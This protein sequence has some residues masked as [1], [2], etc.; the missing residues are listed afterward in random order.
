MTELT[1]CPQCVSRVH[2]PHHGSPICAD[3]DCDCVEMLWCNECGSPW[4]CPTK[5][6]HVAQRAAA[7]RGATEEDPC[8]T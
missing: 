5:R 2:H 3:P 4:P 7:K 1:K 8:P 6:E